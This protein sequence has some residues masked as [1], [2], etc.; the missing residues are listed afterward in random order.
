MTSLHRLCLLIAI[1]LLSCSK[2]IPSTPILDIEI[3]GAGEISGTLSL[4]ASGTL[5]LSG[6]GL[7]ILPDELFTD[8][9][10]P[11]D[12]GFVVVDLVNQKLWSGGSG[13]TIRLDWADRILADG[14]WTL[15]GSD[16]TN[17][18]NILTRATGDTR[19]TQPGDDLPWADLTDIPIYPDQQPGLVPVMDAQTGSPVPGQPP[20]IIVFRDIGWSTIMSPSAI[21]DALADVATSG[22]YTDLSGTPTLAT[23]ATS[24]SYTDL[25]DLPTLGTMSAESAADYVAIAPRLLTDSADD[26]SLDWQGRHLLVGPQPTVDW[27]S[28]QL[29][30]VSPGDVR[31]DWLDRYLYGSWEIIG[32]LDV[33]DLNISGS[34]NIP[35]GSIQ[36]A[37]LAPDAVGAIPAGTTATSSSGSL[38][39]SPEANGDVLR[40]T[41]NGDVTLTLSS[42]QDR[43]AS[44]SVIFLQDVSGSRNLTWGGTNIRAEGGT[45]PAP[46]STANA[47]DIYTFLWDGQA[48]HLTNHL[49][50]LTNL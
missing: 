33:D 42:M 38:T 7:L 15:P 26:E 4:G 35:A 37:D 34:L 32:N 5:D 1:T 11:I 20:E 6:D 3:Q 47:R 46:T 40:L 30:G 50:N 18:D 2:A 10:S 9:L 22:D 24:G 13:S 8:F 39:W 14:P 45:I 17:A 43:P 25:D 31:V 16:L 29:I 27:G 21:W 44:V 23:V 48:F 28:S 36:P 19:Y 49:Q 41:A 12:D